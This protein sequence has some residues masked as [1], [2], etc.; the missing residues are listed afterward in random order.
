MCGRKIGHKETKSED[1]V[2]VRCAMGRKKQVDIPALTDAEK[3]VA[4]LI[5][6]RGK[7]RS[8]ELVQL[9]EQEMDWKKST[10]YTLLKRIENKGILSNQDGMIYSLV[11][12]E[13]FEASQ[14]RQYVEHSFGGS[15]PRFIA[16]FTREERLSD[17]DIEEIQKVINRYKGGE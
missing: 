11:S 16:A 9:C 7:M 14:S 10:T 15:L 5:W 13:D 6:E 4:A 17:Q 12:R 3:S 8:M 1:N 2:E